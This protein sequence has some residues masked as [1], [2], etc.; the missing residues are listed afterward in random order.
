MIEKWGKSGLGNMGRG[1]WR[2]SNELFSTYL[3]DMRTFK[4]ST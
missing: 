4:F 2:K 1:G 3:R